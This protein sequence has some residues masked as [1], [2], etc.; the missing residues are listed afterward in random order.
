MRYLQ[1]SSIL[2]VAGN[3]GGPERTGGII[4]D[5]AGV[6]HALE[7]AVLMA[8]GDVIR[9]AGIGLKSGLG[10]TYHKT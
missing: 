10:R 5:D 6:S 9:A 4:A 3:V 2:Q 1:S 7:R 8:T